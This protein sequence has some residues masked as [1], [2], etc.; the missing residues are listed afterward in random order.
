MLLFVLLS[1]P[2]LLDV[3]LQVPDAALAAVG[4]D[5]RVQRGGRELQLALAEAAVLARRRDQVL[6]GDR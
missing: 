1:I 3:F 4:A 2:Y 5:E 6:L